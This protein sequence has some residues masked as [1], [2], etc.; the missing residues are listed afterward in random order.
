VG[1]GLSVSLRGFDASIRD[2]YPELFPDEPDKSADILEWRFGAN[3]HGNARFAV[4]SQGDAVAGMIALVPTRLRSN[5]GVMLG[6]QAIDTVVDPAF[7][8]RGL[9]VAMGSAA[10]DRSAL[11]GD[12][13]WGF[14]NANAAPGWYGRLGWTDFGAVPLLVRPLR[15]SFVLGRIHPWLATIGIPLIRAPQV[16]ARVY[17]NGAELGREFGSLWEQVAS[18]FGIAVDRTGDWMRWRLMDKPHADY[19]CVG[20]AGPDRALEAF[21]ATRVADKHGSRLCY[22][23]E[24]IGARGRTRELATLLRA[25]IAR[26][27]HAGAELALAWCPSHAPNYGAY[28]RAGFFPLPPRLRP[29]E[30]NFG[31]RALSDAAQAAARPGARWYVS[32][33]DS[34]TN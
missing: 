23:M 14:P 17:D 21:V 29:I 28:R 33:L 7:R 16:S 4:A 10:Q 24:G 12:L 15:S 1:D 3:P 8:G 5:G 9:F 31:A 19:R 26:A 6:Y 13:L 2:A 30:I 34:D 22:V 18:G 32:F 11:G 27:A 20:T 25:E